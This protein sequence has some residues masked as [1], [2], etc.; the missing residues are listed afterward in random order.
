MDEV[1]GSIFAGRQVKK[2]RNESIIMKDNV[3]IIS[4]CLD[5][6]GNKMRVYEPPKDQEVYKQR[7][8][9]R[10]EVFEK[11]KSGVTPIK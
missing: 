10:M 2:E 8:E 9:A 3:V 7:N 1:I 4:N 5:K 6:N 11:L